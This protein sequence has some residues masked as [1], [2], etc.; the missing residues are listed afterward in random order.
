VTGALT[1]D[2]ETDLVPADVAVA[3]ATPEG[4]NGQGAAVDG[5]GEGVG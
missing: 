3:D 1:P 2:L 5:N 4:G